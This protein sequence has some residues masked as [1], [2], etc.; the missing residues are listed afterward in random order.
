M[1]QG[2]FVK[3]T[4]ALVAIVDVP[5]NVPIFLQQTAHMTARERALCAVSAGVATAAVLLV[6]TFAGAAILGTFAITLDAFRVVGGLVLVLI[7]LQLLGLMGDGEPS[8]GNADSASPVAVGVFPMAVPMLAGPG[9]IAAVMVSAGQAGAHEAHRLHV[10]T[11]VLAVSA[12]I[13]AGL[14]VAGSM[15]RF[16]GPVTQNVLNRLLGI[17]V[18]ALGTEFILEG[19]QGFY[20]I[21][22]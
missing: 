7:A 18:G 1:E 14:L 20:D 17:I 16:I 22:A 2:E 12:V 9:A 10:A 11:A 13:V 15:R 3:L 4:V 21:G 6:F 19:V 8:F 5:G